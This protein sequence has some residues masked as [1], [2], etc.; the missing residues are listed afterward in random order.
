MFTTRSLLASAALAG[1]CSMAA[2]QP[3]NSDQHTPDPAKFAQHKQTEL[4]HIAQRMQTLQTL[5]MCVQDAA[6]PTA[7]RACHQSARAAMGHDGQ[8]HESG[9]GRSTN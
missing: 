7:L 3:G 6:D 8:S 2:A 5:Q 9:Q 4:Q 1:I